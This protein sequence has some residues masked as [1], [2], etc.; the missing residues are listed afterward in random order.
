MNAVDNAT[1]A[2]LLAVGTE[3][4]RQDDLRDAGR[5]AFTLADP[6]GL[7]TSAKLALLT[8]EL[9]EVAKEANTLAGMRQARGTLGTRQALR[10][11]LVQLAAEA[12]AWI[13]ALDDE[14]G[15][16]E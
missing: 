13:E 12:V 11:E 5:F 15:G 2:A 6:L 10:V 14:I 9:G 1:W 7:H 16:I 3:R 4:R 8:E